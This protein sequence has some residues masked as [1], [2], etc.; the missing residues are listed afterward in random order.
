[1]DII[2]GVVGVIGLMLAIPWIEIVF[3]HYWDHVDWIRRKKP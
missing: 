1:M 2:V 3:T